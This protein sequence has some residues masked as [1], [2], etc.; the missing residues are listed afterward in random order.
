MIGSPFF[1]KA[2]L[3]ALIV[4]TAMKIAPME[5]V[6][7]MDMEMSQGR[8]LE[9]KVDIDPGRVVLPQLTQEEIDQGWKLLFD[10]K[11]TNGW[12]RFNGD[13]FP[14]IGW[15]IDQGI[16]IIDPVAG[17]KGLDIITDGE[18]SDFEFSVEFR[19]DPG[20]NSGIKY[21]L[22]KE[23]NLGL[24]YQ[25]LDDATH[26]DATMGR[27]GN[28]LQGSLYDLIAPEKDRLDKPA[29]EWNEA[30]IKSKGRQ[31]EH[32]LNGQ[33]IVS[34]ERGSK[35]FKD[36]VSISKYKEIEGFAT[37]DKSPILLQHHGYIVAFRNIKIRSL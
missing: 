9:P 18:F 8:M 33:L 22:L 31:V 23:T 14:E 1:Q 4:Y 7:L 17:G 12:K 13:P 16:L 11:T 10:G 34:Y 24:E 3:F 20:A 29:G 35:P 15:K 5:T 19:V 37:P 21:F 28:R 25:I 27:D 30:R 36:L 2:V 26:P 6:S 32:W